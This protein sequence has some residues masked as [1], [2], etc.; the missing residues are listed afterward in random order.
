MAQGQAMEKFK[1]KAAST[2][3]TVGGFTV[4]MYVLEV[5]N[6]LVSNRLNLEFGIRPRTFSSLL[7]ILTAPLLHG[8][9]AHLI[10]NTGPF[11]VLGILVFL[12]SGRVFIGVLATVWVASGLVVWLIGANGVTIG[13]SGVI[14]GFFGYLVTRGIVTKHVLDIVLA[15]VV[16]I[17]YGSLLWGV[18]PNVASNISWQGHLGGLIGGVLSAFLFRARRQVAQSWVR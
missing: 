18:L 10:A 15:V 4:V 1:E 8:S 16:M 9:W 13:M 17:G 11:I 14:F 12:V 6:T 5:I 3:V 7:D 2:T